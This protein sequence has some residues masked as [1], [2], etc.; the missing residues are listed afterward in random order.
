MMIADA[1]GIDVSGKEPLGA[2]KEAIQAVRDLK[3]EIGLTETLK[4]FNVP[5]DKDKLMP[6]VE[7]AS[8]D[9]QAAYNCRQLEEEDIV[10]LYLKAM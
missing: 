3:S 2:T 4:D 9:T 8:G 7:L 10:N 1:M 5:Q 6:L